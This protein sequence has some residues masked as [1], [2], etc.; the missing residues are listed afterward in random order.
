M[1]GCVGPE[2]FSWLKAADRPRAES[3]REERAEGRNSA[4]LKAEPARSQRAAQAKLAPV[5]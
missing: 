4:V 3:D 5:A 2:K 1:R